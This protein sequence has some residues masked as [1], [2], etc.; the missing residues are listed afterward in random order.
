[1]RLRLE[2]GLDPHE[3]SY[4]EWRGLQ[5]EIRDRTTELVEAAL[6][7]HGGFVADR[8]PADFA[9]YWLYYDFADPVA[10]TE[11]VMARARRDMAAFDMV[12]ILPWGALAL[13]D[14]GIRSANPWRQLHFQ[15]LVEGMTEHLADESGV[16]V[17][18]LPR[19]ITAL[20]E[21][22]AWALD[23]IASAA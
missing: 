23:L 8:S 9:A 20:A 15:T 5:T 12:L 1:M 13:E 10:E 19:E 17:H 18:R 2:A 4:A 6:A 7:S 3:L 16:R 21:R 14:D 22:S 11:A